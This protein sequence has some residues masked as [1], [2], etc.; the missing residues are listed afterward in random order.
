MQTKEAQDFDVCPVSQ[1]ARRGCCHSHRP[2]AHPCGG[3][4]AQGEKS[5]LVL[6]QKLMCFLLGCD[7]S[8]RGE[9]RE[10]VL[11]CLQAAST[12]GPSAGF[13]LVALEPRRTWKG[14]Q[15]AYS[16]GQATWS[17]S[18]SGPH[19]EWAPPPR[20]PPSL[21]GELRPSFEP[22]LRASESCAS[23][24]RLLPGTSARH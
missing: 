7:G 9:G 8:R 3:L 14:A 23:G 22:S 13:F 19:G 15:T 2:W 24:F 11:P 6:L 12:F 20:T 10:V 16:Q 1:A 21:Q 5:G 17:T 18:K 4:S